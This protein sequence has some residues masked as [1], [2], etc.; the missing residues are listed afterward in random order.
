MGAK[1]LGRIN[2]WSFEEDVQGL[3]AALGISRETI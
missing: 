1:S 2:T 3:R